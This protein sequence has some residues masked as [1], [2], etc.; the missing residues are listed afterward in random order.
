MA[1]TRSWPGATPVRVTSWSGAWP[2]RARSSPVVRGLLATADA[3]PSSIL[4][5]GDAEPSSLLSGIAKMS[6]QLAGAM[7]GA[8][9]SRQSAPLVPTPALLWRKRRG[10]GSRVLSLQRK[11]KRMLMCHRIPVTI[12]PLAVI[13]SQQLLHTTADLA[14]QCKN[15]RKK[16]LG[17]LSVKELLRQS[18]HGMN[19]NFLI[20]T[21]LRMFFFDKP[22]RA[23]DSGNQNP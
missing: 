19:L 4:A 8:S 15:P 17:S 11:S 14:V 12:F 2:G 20:F 10:H 9:G 6:L 21:S 22:R 1:R 13:C 23:F 18:L 3:G 16:M 7:P 5:E